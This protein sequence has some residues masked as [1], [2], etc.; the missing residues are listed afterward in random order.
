MSC[1]VTRFYA[2][3][4]LAKPKHNSLQAEVTNGDQLQA[5]LTNDDSLQ[6][7]LTNDDSLQAELPK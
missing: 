4:Y 7:E 2:Q 3:L 5:E 6:A 1:L